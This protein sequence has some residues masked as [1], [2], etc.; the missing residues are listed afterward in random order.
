[1]SEG[2]ADHP[3]KRFGA[4]PVPVRNWNDLPKD[5]WLQDNFGVTVLV[6][7]YNNSH[8]TLSRNCERTCILF[9]SQYLQILK[10]EAIMETKCVAPYFKGGNRGLER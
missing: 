7:L 9:S 1:M 5:T 4:S 6:A 3:G 2:N 10:M 8:I